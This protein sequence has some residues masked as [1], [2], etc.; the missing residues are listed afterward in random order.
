MKNEVKGLDYYLSLPYTV[1]LRRDNEGDWIARV[2][3]LQ[4]CVAHGPTEA[5]ALATLHEIKRAWIE[6]AIESGDV[7]PEPVGEEELPSGKWVQRVPRTLHKKLA[8]LAR[9]ENV[10]LNQ[11]ATSILAEAAGRKAQRY[12]AS[13]STGPHTWSWA[14]FPETAHHASTWR[15]NQPAAHRGVSFVEAL[16]FAGGLIESKETGFEIKQHAHPKVLAHE[17]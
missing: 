11:L 12:A 2:D 5:D 3:E 4:G 17:A 14:E 7:I 8:D 1:V 10:S 9:K 6:D 16:E 13:I 15:I